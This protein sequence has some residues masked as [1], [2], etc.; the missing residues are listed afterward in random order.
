[1]ASRAYNEG[2]AID[3]VVRRIETRDQSIRLND[4]RSPD[5][6]NDPD[7]LRRVD[8]VC[9]IGT[10]LHAFEH[11]GIEPFADQIELEVRNNKLFAPIVARFSNRSDRELWEFRVPVEASANLTGAQV[12]RVQDILISWIE[13]NASRFPVTVLYDRYANPQLGERSSASHFR[14]RAPRIAR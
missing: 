14:F 7:P 4:G 13:A 6:L 12:K 8:Y 11:T 5:D 3:A 1:M 9:T 10:R 2:K